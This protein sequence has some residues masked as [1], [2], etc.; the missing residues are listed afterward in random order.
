MQWRPSP[1]FAERTDP[2]RFVILHG[3][4]MLNDDEALDR[5]CDPEAQVSCHYFIKPDGTLL[6]LVKDEHVA[7]HAGQSQWGDVVGLN[8][9][10]IGVEL[11]NAGEDTATPYTEAQYITLEKLLAG[12]LQKH[13]IPPQNVL[14]HSDIAPHRKN[15]PGKYF[16]WARL[17]QKG[18]ATPWQPSNRPPLEALRAAGYVGE[19]ADILAAFQRRYLPQYVSG[20]LCAKTAKFIGGSTTHTAT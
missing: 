17:E 12:L 2:L 6:Q 4:W 11:S 18:L 9:Y 3:T 8:K 13:T 10:S 7:W 15:D 1:N 20:I 14:G 19:D 5:L 16:D